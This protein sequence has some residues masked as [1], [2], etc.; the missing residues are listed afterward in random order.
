MYNA[1]QTY[2]DVVHFVHVYVIEPHPLDPD[3]S[4]YQGEVWEALYSHRS[5]P[6]TYDGRVALAREIEALLER[7]QLMLVDEL[8]PE[9]RNNPLWCSYGPA[10]NSGYLIDQTGEL[11]VV[12]IWIDVSEME[13]TIDAILAE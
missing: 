11:R 1:T 6:K 7:S 10:P 13:E 5:Q 12:N 9:S 8:T 3:P 4:P 2:G